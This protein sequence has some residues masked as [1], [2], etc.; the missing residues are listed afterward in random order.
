MTDTARFWLADAQ[1]TEC[2]GA[3]LA[4]SLYTVPLTISVRGELGSGKTTFIK[5]FAQALGIREALTSPTYALE[6][7]YSH[8]S[9]ELL[10]IDLF[11]LPAEEGQKLVSASDDHTGF[12]CIEWTNRLPEPLQEPLIEVAIEEKNS[13]RSMNMTFRDIPLPSRKEILAWREETKLPDHIARHCDVVGTVAEKLA[14]ALHER[15]V[16]ARSRTLRRGGEVH[17]LFRFLDFRLTGNAS[18]DED[19]PSEEQ[20]RTW[21]LW[22]ERYSHLRHEAACREFLRERGYLALAEIVAVHG[23]TLPSPD[24]TTTEQ[25]ILFYADKRVQIDRV[26]SLEERFKD[27]NFRYAGGV[28]SERS[29]IWFDEAKRVERELLPGGTPL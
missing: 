6:Q 28:E 21:S 14:H 22:R 26:V 10:H 16:V 4:R 3:S 5:G 9:L 11:R 24:R 7:R 1:K 25:K 12:R 17:D 18:S 23:L 19:K 15:C 20:Q 8:G 29:R 2:V 27:F 13:G